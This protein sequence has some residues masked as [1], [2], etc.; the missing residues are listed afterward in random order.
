M[1]ACIFRVDVFSGSTAFSV[2]HS[3]TF[4]CQ[5]KHCPRVDIM[6]RIV[7]RNRPGRREVYVLHQLGGRYEVFR[8]QVLPT[9]YAHTYVLL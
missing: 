5:A 3:V 1:A 9:T 7:K 6:M 4:F 2:V 8:F